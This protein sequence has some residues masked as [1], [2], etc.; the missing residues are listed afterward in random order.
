M[1]FINPNFLYA[2][3]VLAIPI[4]LHLFH[5][6]RFKKVYFTNVKFLQEV[7]EETS[8][9]SKLRNLLVLLSRILA[10]AFLVFAFAQPFIPA[11]NQEKRKGKPTVSVFLDNSFS[12]NALSDDV[13]LLEKEKQLAEEIVSSYA[14]DVQFQILTN[15]FEGRHQRLYSREDAINLIEEVRSTP[16]VKELSKAFKRQLQALNTSDAENKV[17]YIISDFQANI[18]DLSAIKDTSVAINL[19]PLQA[20]QERNVTI[21]SAWFEAPVQMINHNNKLLVRVRNY[22]NEDVENVRISLDYQGQNRPVGTISIKAQA[23]EV[24]TVTIT[25]LKVGWHEATLQITDFPIQFDDNYFLSFHVA[26]MVRV[27]AINEGGYNRFISAA[28][29]NVTSVMVN[30]LKYGDFPKYDMILLDDLKLISSGLAFEL[31]KYVQ[32]GG[33]LLV[34]PGAQADVNTYNSFFDLLKVDQLRPF[35]SKVR[36]V[37]RINTDEFVFN[38]VFENTNSQLTLPITQGNYPLTSFSARKATTLLRYRDGSNFM[39]KYQLGE[40]NVYL[41]AAPLEEENSDLVRNGEVFIPM[42]YKMAISAGQS[43]PI[44]YT[45]GKDNR[46]E[47]PYEVTSEEDVYKLSGAKDEFIPQ[48][49]IIEGKI[50]LTVSDEVKEAGF[51]VLKND[52]KQDVAHFAFNFDRKESDL[53]CLAVADLKKDLGSNVSVLEASNPEYL[54]QMISEQSQGIQLWKWCVIFVLI[55]LLVETLL[56]RLWKK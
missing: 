55:F 43:K 32:A 8:A 14:P 44:S 25:P 47:A 17:A 2:L 36:K 33:N 31:K 3:G 49:R 22:S 4:I 50:I 26:E 20:V 35:E 12:M 28:L 41:S 38:G 51:F 27:L 11:K 1:Q 48:Q 37:N 29:P 30:A 56:L 52:K 39:V 34:F 9:R 6:R 46:L 10:L 40:G 54:T 5:F 23:Y 13:K 16:N 18:S 15:D 7:K 42:L 24:D 53:K 21:D 19:I 45:I